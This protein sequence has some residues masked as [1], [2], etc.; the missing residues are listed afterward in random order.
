MALALATGQAGA[1]ALPAEKAAGSGAAQ[2]APAVK[3]DP[4]NG[5]WSLVLDRAIK[6]KPLTILLRSKDGKWKEAICTAFTYNQSIHDIDVSRLKLAGSR[7]K[8]AVKVT[9]KPDAWVPKDK[10]PISCRLRVE[11]AAKDGAVTGTHKG[12]CGEAEV[13]GAVSGKLEA[14]KGEMKSG[15]VQLRLENAL[16][17]GRAHLLRAQVS[18]GLANGKPRDGRIS[19]FDPWHWRGRVEALK[20]K[21]AADALSGEIKAT[22]RSRP[23]AVSTGTYTFTLDGKVIGSVVAGT[24]KA[25]LG[26]RQL[27]GGIFTG[28]LKGTLWET[29]TAALPQ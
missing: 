17:G 25:R 24:F 23:G 10:K 15:S 16:T 5:I 29:G 7:V 1:A 26:D 13:S 18:F 2:K 4:S 8:G 12:K 28:T 11:A 9:I 19:C 21:L 20:V 14:P 22:V 6:G 27:E 3:L